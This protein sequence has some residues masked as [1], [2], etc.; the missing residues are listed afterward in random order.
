[1]LAGMVNPYVPVPISV[2]RLVWW[3]PPLLALAWSGREPAKLAL[4]GARLRIGLIRRSL[5]L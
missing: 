5:T 4:S 2:F 1:M 3:T